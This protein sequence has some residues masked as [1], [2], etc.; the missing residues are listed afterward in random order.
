MTGVR[1]SA[2]LTHATWV[3]VRNLADVDADPRLSQAHLVRDHRS[4]LPDVQ[5]ALLTVMYAGSRDDWRF[6]TLVSQSPQHG[7]QAILVEGTQPLLSSTAALARRLGV[8]ILGTPDPLRAHQALLQ[9]IQ[10]PELEAARLVLKVLNHAPRSGGDIEDVLRL[11]ARALGRPI[12]LLDS[13]GGLLAGETLREDDPGPIP[14]PDFSDTGGPQRVPLD[15]GSLVLLHPVQPAGAPTW[16][17]VRLPAVVPAEV[18][19]IATAL[20]AVAPLA[21]SHLVLAR[22][23]LERDAGR[24]MSVLGELLQRPTATTTARRAAELGWQ[25]DGWHIGIRIGVNEDADLTASRNEVTATFE[26]HELP[27][28]VVEYGDGWTAWTTA[29]H[30][31]TAVEVQQTAATI[32]RV[33]RRLRETL[34]VHVGVGRPHAG[35]EGLNRSIGEATDAARLAK[36]RPESGQFLHVDRL[37]LA[38]LLLA[39]TRTD[40]FQPAARSLL[41]PLSHAAGDLVRTLATYLDAESSLSDTAAVLGVHRNT[42][43]ARIA[44]VESLLGV[45]LEIPDDRLALHLACRTSLAGAPA[46]TDPPN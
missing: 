45:D 39:W 4:S 27:C 35:A 23:R 15:D 9:L 2:L 17:A 37:G 40:T 36:G 31:P 32:R 12:A 11:S 16:L 21:Q 13:H 29:N 30:E 3:D 42:V 14:L 43:A 28:V 34:D 22:M 10:Q 25:L 19:A 44:K 33:H 1:L 5:D 8:P 7:V 18:E 46:P 24:R 38:Q 26:R 41:E 20:L 6:D